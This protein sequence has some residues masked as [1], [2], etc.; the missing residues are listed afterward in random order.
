MVVQYERLLIEKSAGSLD[1]LQWTLYQAFPP[2]RTLITQIKESLRKSSS[3]E[4]DIVAEQATL[5]VER[6][7]VLFII[8]LLTS[9]FLVYFGLKRS[10][11]QPIQ[12]TINLLEQMSLGRV[13]LRL[14]QP[15]EDEVGRMHAALNRFAEQLEE[16]VT[17]LKLISTGDLNAEVQ[18]TSQHDLLAEAMNEMRESLQ[19]S[20]G[21][22][23]QEAN[24]HK[25]SR[26]A[27]ENT[28]A[29][30]IQSEK[31]SSLGQLVA[32]VAHE[33]NNPVNFLQ[34]NFYAIRQ[35]VGEVK[36][37]LWGSPR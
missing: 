20:Q 9:S 28:Q 37:L 35:S 21:K 29:Q 12:K 18:M 8:V 23:V 34:S 3:D 14:N 4:M 2:I 10:V 16:K 13:D 11:V 30:L 26:E 17:H 36:T 25:R 5:L 6:S 19:R 7:V 33:I 24:E 1:D 32:G 27:L 22:L 15:G 31:M